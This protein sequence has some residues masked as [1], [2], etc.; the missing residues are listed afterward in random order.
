MYR[1]GDGTPFPIQ[2][3]FIDTL[4]AA[5]EAAAGTFAAAAEIEERRDKAREA[6]KE[7]EDD[8]RRFGQMEGAIEA[9]VLP[10]RPSSDRA[11]ALPQQAAFR[12]LHAS[13]AAIA[14]IR[15]QVE[16]KLQLLAGEPRTARAME[17]ARAALAAF[18]ERHQLPDTAWRHEWRASGAGATAEATAHAGRFLATFDVDVAAPWTSVVRVGALVP[19]LVASVPRKRLLGGTRRA[20]LA[21]DRCGLVHVE[22]TPERHTLVLREHAGKPSP[23]WR[24]VLRDGDADGATLIAVTAEGRAIGSEVALEPDA[25]APFVALGDAVD[26]ARDA[27]RASGRHLRAL[28]VGDAALEALADPALAGRALLGVLG[29][30]IKEIRA[31]SR[32]PGELAIKRDVGDGHRDELFVP[33][34]AVERRFASL[35]PVYRREFEQL[36]LGREATDATDATDADD[37]SS[38]D[39]MTVPGPRS[40]ADAAAQAI[41]EIAATPD[42]PVPP[43]PAR[44]PAQPPPS[45]AARPAARPM[46]LEP[47]PA[48]ELP[49]RRSPPEPPRPVAR[50]TDAPPL[51]DAPP[52][53]RHA[54]PPP[55]PAAGAVTAT[56]STASAPEDEVLE[57]TTPPDALA[58]LPAVPPTLPRITQ[59]KTA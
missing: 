54:A 53:P 18:F 35:P 32:V 44:A 56:A 16:Q 34:E 25:A 11:A 49:R 17:R 43:V 50:G 27:A 47:A 52:P 39:L 30:L 1:F 2:E 58:R 59:L 51:A 7:A 13:R 57:V 14:A 36:G 26:A 46:P 5:V 23:G 42:T 45:P 22:R 33:R 41:A 15:A 31:R 4:V 40:V 29:P 37:D 24:V 20:R 38:A 55:P 6:R 28:R 9:A 3:N 10:H 19:G 8:L 48:T 12:A 21:L